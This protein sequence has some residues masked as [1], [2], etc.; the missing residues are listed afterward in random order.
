MLSF[1][2]KIFISYLLIFLLFLAVMFP[3]ASQTV[4]RIVN[5]SIRDRSLEL[6]A[7]I[8]TA[9]DDD[10]LIQRLKDQ[11]Y[12]IF[13]RVSVI[14]ND[15]KVL[16]DSYTKRLIGPSFNKNL[17]TGHPEVEEAFKEGLGYHEGYSKLLRQD[18]AYIAK[19]F[20]FHGKTYVLRTAFPFKFIREMTRDF[21][22]GFFSLALAAFLLCSIMTW[23]IIGYLT[24]P[25]Q[26][27]IKAINP[28]QEGLTKTIPEIKIMGLRSA[29]EFNKLAETLNSLSANIQKQINTLTNERN[30]KEA[31]LE[32]LVEGVVAVDNQLNV[33]YANN[34][35]LK[36]LGFEKQLLLGQPF[37]KTSQSKCQELLIDCQRQNQVITDNLQIKLKDSNTYLD[38]VAA[39]KKEQT[40]AVL[41]MQDKSTHYKLLE[42]RRDFIANASHELKTP[43]TIIHGFAEFLHDNPDLPRS[44]CIEITQKIVRNCDRMATLIRDLLALTD[45]ENLPD[46]RLEKFDLLHLIQ[47]CCNLV[48]DVAPQ[49]QISLNHPHEDFTLL[50]DISLMEMALINLI[51]NAVKYSKTPAEVTITLN[52]IADT[53]TIVIA[54]KGIGIPKIDLEHIFERFYTVNKAHSRKLGGSGL[55]LSIVETV[56]KKHRGTISVLSELG[57]GTT[58]TM[59]LPNNLALPH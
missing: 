41:V 18:F 10:A 22:I 35:A 34:M 59:Q 14:T 47:V 4:K 57:Q 39:P 13:F 5:N 36:F 19:A 50:A 43:I 23:F 32:S 12:L 7:R 11:K 46:S 52:K 44:H 38:I 30:E 40:G 33:T 26:Q 53:I 1:R 20:N 3:F 2:Q 54:D 48:K 56:I 27:I 49:S 51:E 58:F 21:E 28:Y 45:I 8:Q 15:R 9:A 37:E 29:N 42:M 6:I 25:I 17:A 31:I 16:Y 24:A 55:G